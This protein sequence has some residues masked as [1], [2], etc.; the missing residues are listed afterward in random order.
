MAK[1]GVLG[2]DELTKNIKR[3]NSVVDSELQ[4]AASAVGQAVRN[5]AVRSIQRGSPSGVT[6]QKYSPKRTHR[7]SA[8]GQP[9]ATDTGR[10]AGSIRVEQ[11]RLTADIGTDLIYGK[12]LEFGTTKMAARP[13]LVPAL[14][15]N[16]EKWRERVAAA[17]EKG[18]K[19]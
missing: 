2:L 4:N 16:R 3:F 15:K 17:I 18:V 5:D 9:P 10:L 6:Y 1:A 11:Q 19:K 7:A 8:P 13:F 12:Y 14:E